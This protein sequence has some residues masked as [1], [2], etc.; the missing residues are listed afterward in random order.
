MLFPCLATAILGLLLLDHQQ[1]HV[2]SFSMTPAATRWGKSTLVMNGAS[3]FSESSSSSGSGGGGDEHSSRRT[4]FKDLEPL[5]QSAARR[6]RLDRD[7]ETRGKFAK[8]GND[9]W[10]LRT[11][12]KR[13]RA[14]LVDAI[15]ISGGNRE[16]EIDIRK[17]LRKLEQQDPEL[18]YRIQ[19][20]KGLVAQRDGRMEDAE[21]YIRK[22]LA[23]RSRLP[24]YNLEGLWV[25]K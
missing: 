6:A 11:T 9:L 5:V 7:M 2:D 19:M 10:D 16:H 15:T 12:M 4:E 13:L 20:T 22:A 18:M 14:M 25:G 17:R 24:Q 3:Y 1:Y 21:Q 8:Y 23:A